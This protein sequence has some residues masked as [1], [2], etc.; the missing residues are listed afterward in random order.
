MA[1][2]FYFMEAFLLI[3]LQTVS[4]VS[5]HHTYTIIF[6]AFFCNY[7]IDEYLCSTYTMY[8]ALLSAIGT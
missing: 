7:F 1:R 6:L 2:H 3:K 5:P 8:K 4:K